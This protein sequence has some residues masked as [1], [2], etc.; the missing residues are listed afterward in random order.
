MLGL[1]SNRDRPISC[2]S[3]LLMKSGFFRLFGEAWSGSPAEPTA[4]ADTS[5]R[6]AHDP[7]REDGPPEETVR[8]REI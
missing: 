6:L 3:T 5:S 1:G 8:A 4:P 7:P 2:P